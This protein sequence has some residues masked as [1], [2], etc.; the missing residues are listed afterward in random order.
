VT[1]AEITKSAVAEHNRKAAILAQEVIKEAHSALTDE[2]SLREYTKHTTYSAAV[3][4]SA[5]MLLNAQGYTT[6]IKGASRWSLWWNS[7][8]LQIVVSGWHKLPHALHAPT[9]GPYRELTS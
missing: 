5:C 9:D 8:N 1:P 2:P 4:L 6:A 7:G 3:C